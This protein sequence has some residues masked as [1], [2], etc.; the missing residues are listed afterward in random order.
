MMVSKAW[1]YGLVAISCAVALAAA[2]PTDAASSCFTIA[3]VVSSVYG[4]RG[5]GILFVGLSALSFDY[6]F[7]PPQHHFA[8]QLTSYPRFAAFLGAIVLIVSLI[9]A[10][11]RAE[12]SRRQI[13]AQYRVITDTSRDAILSIDDTGRIFF[14]NPAAVTAFGWAAS[15][16]IGQPL[17]MVIPDFRFAEHATRAEL[18]GRRKDGLAF[19][20]EVSFGEVAN[21]ERRSFTGFI[22]DI[23]VR[24]RAEAALRKSESYLAQAQKL[25]KMGSFGWN[26]STGEIFWTEEMFRVFGINPAIKPSLEI[27]LERIHPDD[28]AEVGDIPDRAR[29]SGADLDFEHRLLM[30]DGSVKHLHVLA[31]AAGESGAVE[32]IG[33]AMDITSR[34]QTEEAVR[35]SELYLRLLVDSIPAWVSTMKPD[36]EAETANRQAMDYIRSSGCNVGSQFFISSEVLPEHGRLR[37]FDDNEGS[38]VKLSFD[39]LRLIAETSYVRMDLFALKPVEDDQGGF[40]DVPHHQQS[41]LGS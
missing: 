32:Y 15:D 17:T 37:L 29:Q 3:V 38:N 10:K 16:L 18:T 9:E 19:P 34:K 23:S 20:V 7:P 22:R 41:L 27:V 40:D 1:R 30:A 21:V 4:G 11:R 36:G 26:T 33:A 2:L 28:R 12:K 24:E 13:D 39:G 31:R 25:S 5:P 6:F 14:V 8:V 35:A